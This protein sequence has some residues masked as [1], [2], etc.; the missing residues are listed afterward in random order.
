[1]S[2]IFSDGTIEELEIISYEAD[3]INKLVSFMMNN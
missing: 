3:D 1:M 2:N